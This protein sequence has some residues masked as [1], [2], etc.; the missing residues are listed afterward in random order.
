[1]FHHESRDNITPF[2]SEMLYNSNSP[3]ERAGKAHDLGDPKENLTFASTQRGFHQMRRKNDFVGRVRENIM[4]R[5][6]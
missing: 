3:T 2:L 1:M 5:Q 6:Y 4:M